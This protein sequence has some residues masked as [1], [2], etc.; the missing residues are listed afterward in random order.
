[1]ED[2]GAMQLFEHATVGWQD[3]LA[4][5][6]GGNG[7]HRTDPPEFVDIMFR[8]AAEHGSVSCRALDKEALCFAIGEM[9]TRTIRFTPFHAIRVLLAAVAYVLKRSPQVLDVYGD[10]AE[11]TLEVNGQQMHFRVETANTGSETLFFHIRKL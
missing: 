5:C 3:N 4:T 2:K 6:R 9:E 7:N 10:S 11:A 8:V 1:M